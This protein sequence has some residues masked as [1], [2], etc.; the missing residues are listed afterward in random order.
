M[1][2]LILVFAWLFLNRYFSPV[3]SKKNVQCTKMPP[4]CGF[5]RNNTDMGPEMVSLLVLA[6]FAYEVL[7][8]VIFP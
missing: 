3:T 1:H 2:K 7:K 4:K 6:A 8:H 5:M